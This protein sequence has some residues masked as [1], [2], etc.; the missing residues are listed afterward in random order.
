MLKMPA[1]SLMVLGPRHTP[2]S[3]YPMD[4]VLAANL[5]FA[6]NDESNQMVLPSAIRDGQDLWDSSMTSLQPFPTIFVPISNIDVS[7]GIDEKSL[8]PAEFA[9]QVASLTFLTE[10]ADMFV[11]HVS[12]CMTETEIHHLL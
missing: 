9:Q 5:R 4:S 11:A 8:T 10:S 3:S 2:L 7:I 1:L 12:R 6:R